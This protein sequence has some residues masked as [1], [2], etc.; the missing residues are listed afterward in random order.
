MHSGT[1]YST[2]M[3]RFL[4]GDP[5]LFFS[6]LHDCEHRTKSQLLIFIDDTVYYLPSL[7]I[8]FIFLEMF[9]ILLAFPKLTDKLLFFPQY[10]QAFL[11]YLRLNSD[12]SL[13]SP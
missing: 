6:K 3:S 7:F 11:Q 12:I 5:I 2:M 4:Y 13:L 1:I 10:L 8:L 9:T